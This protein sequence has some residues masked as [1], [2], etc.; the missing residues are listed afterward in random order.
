MTMGI[1]DKPTSRRT[2]EAERVIG[3]VRNRSIRHGLIRFSGRSIWVSSKPTN[4]QLF[5]KHMP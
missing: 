1:D 5:F 3:D 4:N 2:T